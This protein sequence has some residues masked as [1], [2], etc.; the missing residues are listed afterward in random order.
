MINQLKHITSYLYPLVVEQ[1]VGKVTPYLEVNLV[2]GKCTLDSTKVNYSYG[3]LHKIFDITFHKCA[4]KAREVKNVLILGFG[5]GSVASLLREKYNIQAEITGIEKDQIV[6]DLAHKYFNISRFKK[7]ELVC[8][9]AQT[10]VQTCTKQFDVIIVDLFIDDQVP[11]CFHEKE[12]LK[13]LDRLLLY[14]GVLFFNKIVNTPK[15]KAEF[16]ELAANMEEI[17]GYSLTYK[18]RRDSTDNYML[19]HDRRTT[20]ANHSFVMNNDKSFFHNKQFVPS[21]NYNKK[22]QNVNFKE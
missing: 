21:F 3:A 15:Q 5:A 20:I 4:L 19:V 8:E 9:D 12:F 6:I 11:K 14:H 10:F 17:L 2:N 18:I 13:Q 7:L 1:R 22:I 16:N